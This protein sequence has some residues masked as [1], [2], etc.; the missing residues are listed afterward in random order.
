MGGTRSDVILSPLCLDQNKKRTGYPA[1]SGN[2]WGS[3]KEGGSYFVVLASVLA[4]VSVLVSTLAFVGAA[5]FDST[6][7]AVIL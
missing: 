2:W 7:V 5:S 1:R 6:L 3:S 4:L